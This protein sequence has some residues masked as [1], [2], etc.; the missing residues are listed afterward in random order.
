MRLCFSADELDNVKPYSAMLMDDLNVAEKMIL[1]AHHAG[2]RS[3]VIDSGTHLTE[4]SG[5]VESVNI[6][7]GGKNLSPIPANVR[8]EH[9]IG[10]GAK[11]KVNV[12]SQGA[13]TRVDVVEPGSGYYPVL[14]KAYPPVRFTEDEHTSAEFTVVASDIGAV[15]KVVPTKAG[16]GYTVGSDIIIDHPTGF[17]A[18]AQI[19][20]VDSQGGIVNVSVSSPGTGYSTRLPSI[21][22]SHPAGKGFA[23][24]AIHTENGRIKSIAVKSGGSGYSPIQCRV[25]MSSRTGSGAKFKP[26]FSAAGEIIGVTL[27]SG[28]SEYSVHDTITVTPSEFHTNPVPAIL[29][30]VV[31]VSTPTST[32]YWQAYRSPVKSH[33]R[34]FVYRFISILEAAKFTVNVVTNPKTLNTL[35]IIISW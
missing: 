35:K 8:V 2:N 11:F 24:G 25:R 15:L 20:E 33:E 5:F 3:V 10:Y 26:L 1:D 21:V 7:S 28:G 27:L 9:S 18:S 32:P 16:T 22:V 31:N 13:I 34:D 12:D 4:T 19:S 14:A 17:G 29:E 6:L 30:P 23:A